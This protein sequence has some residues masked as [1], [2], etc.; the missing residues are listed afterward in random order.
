MSITDIKPRSVPVELRVK[1]EQVMRRRSL[2]WRDTILFLAREVVSP[3]RKTSMRK[4][5]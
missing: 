1:I 5:L 4:T 3:T 2:S